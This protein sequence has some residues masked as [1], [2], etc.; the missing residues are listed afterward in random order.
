MN[1]T[2]ETKEFW[3]LLRNNS[4]VLFTIAVLNAKLLQDMQ[5]GEITI[6]QFVK[7]GKIIRVEASPKISK[8][9]ET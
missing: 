4:P 2:E 1:D 9:I 5:F 7:N 3:R 8:L 6:T